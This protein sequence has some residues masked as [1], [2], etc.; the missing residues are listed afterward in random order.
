MNASGFDRRQKSLRI[1]AK[2]QEGLEYK[3]ELVTPITLKPRRRLNDNAVL[4]YNSLESSAA[5]WPLNMEDGEQ[6]Y[7]PVMR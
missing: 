1:P 7:G 2:I 6:T 3:A 5:G 4:A